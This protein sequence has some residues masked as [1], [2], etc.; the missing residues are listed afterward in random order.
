MPT[1]YVV[2]P[3]GNATVFPSGGAAAD[4]SNLNADNLTS[5]TLPD[6]RFPATLPAASG[7][8]LTALN[9][10]NLASG[11]IA[12]ARISGLTD[13]QIDAA[14][15]IA[16]S[17]LALTGSILNADVNAAAA[18]AYAKLNLSGSIVNADVNAAAAIAWT[19]LSKTGSSLADLTTRSAADLSSGTLPLARL[20]GITNTEIDA[21]AAV[22]WTKL[23]K[24][25]SSLAD[26]ATRSAAD[27]SSGL[28]PD[29]RLPGFTSDGSSRIQQLAFAASQS[30]SADANTLDD[31]EE[32][33][34]TP[35]LGGSTGTSGQAYTAQVGR[36]V[37]VGTL[38]T[39]VG[40]VLL[41]T[42]GTLTG[43]AIISGLPFTT[44][45][46]SNFF[47]GGVISEFSGLAASYVSILTFLSPND[48]RIVL[49]G[50]TAAGTAT[51]SVP[52]GNLSNTTELTFATSFLTDN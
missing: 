39:V 20:S 46:V 51:A 9:A 12:L 16:Y 28:L 29:A 31:Y 6:A 19:K 1:F 2:D 47:Q 41:S 49:Q 23:S 15:A 3:L 13:T 36:Y 42:K 10:S 22:A 40:Y 18:I 45:N 50:L 24:S 44:K 33:S 26:L 32:G 30:A 8:N 48:T 11:T 5:G 43:S 38:V 7:A 21:A 27:L 37:K 4:L 14:A 52:V 25:G 17:K 35:V 34:W